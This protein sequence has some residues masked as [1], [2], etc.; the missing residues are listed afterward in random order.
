MTNT[1]RGSVWI[2]IQICIEFMPIRVW[3]QVQAVSIENNCI[4]DFA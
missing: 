1:K 2:L 4:V 3:K